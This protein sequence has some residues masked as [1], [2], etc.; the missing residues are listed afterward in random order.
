[1]KNYIILC[2][3]K[4]LTVITMFSGMTYGMAVK[5][6]RSL[7]KDGASSIQLRKQTIGASSVKIA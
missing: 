2:K 7:Q 6:M 3:E 1:M 5:K 4:D